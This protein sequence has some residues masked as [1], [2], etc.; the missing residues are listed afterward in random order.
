MNQKAQN[1]RTAS[2]N[3]TD[4]YLAGSSKGTKTDSNIEANDY[5][6]AVLSP[7]LMHQS[8]SKG[9]ANLSNTQ[10]LSNMQLANKRSQSQVKN[11]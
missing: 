6:N 7:P 4:K 3:S 8:S 9:Q 2:N 11:D 10:L 1:T 5:F